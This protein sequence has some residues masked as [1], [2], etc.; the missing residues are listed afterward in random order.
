MGFAF[1]SAFGLGAILTTVFQAFFN[2]YQKK[3][4]LVFQEKKEAYVG[5]LQA[6]HRAAVEDSDDAGKEFAYWQMRCELISN[7][8]VRAAI[9]GIIDTDGNKPKRYIAHDNLK[10]VLRED[11][12]VST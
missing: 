9:Q 2:V 5:L 11:L 3:K 10:D 1:I 6:Y 7:K 4:D 8:K 12:G